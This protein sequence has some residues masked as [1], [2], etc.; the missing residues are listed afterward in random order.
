MSDILVRGLDDET[1]RRLKARA[2]LHGRSLQSEVRLLLTQAAGLS[3]EDVAAMF[4]R[5]KLRFAGRRLA[6]SAELI[7][8]D[9]ER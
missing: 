5:W 7:R 3:G 6:D 4:D 1:V 8:Q 9:R 2:R